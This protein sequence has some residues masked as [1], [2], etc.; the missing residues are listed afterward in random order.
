MIDFIEQNVTY[1]LIAYI[2]EQALQLAKSQMFSFT[3]ARCSCQKNLILI[4]IHGVASSE[5]GI[6]ELGNPEI[7]AQVFAKI[8]I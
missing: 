2:R 5:K 7:I 3:K 8:F 1:I 6:K 4:I